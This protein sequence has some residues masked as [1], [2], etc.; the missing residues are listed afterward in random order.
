VEEDLLE[1]SSVGTDI[2]FSPELLDGAID[3]LLN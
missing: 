3:Y 2:E 1:V